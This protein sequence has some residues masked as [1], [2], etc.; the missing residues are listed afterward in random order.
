[1]ELNSTPTSQETVHDSPSGWVKRHIDEYV[2]TDGAKGK[3]WK[4]T[5]TL[6]LTTRG[7]NS[8][9]LRRTALI[10]GEYGEDF[11]VVASKGGAPEHPDWYLNLSANP[12]VSIQVGP[13]IYQGIARTATGDERRGLWNQMSGIWPDYR[14]YQ[15]RT[16]REIPVVVIEVGE[17][18]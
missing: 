14:E 4:G 17:P 12:S 2:A 11:V 8:G 3:R 18:Q 15:K 6:L 7:R 1:V 16:D 10:Y 9:K 13:D 5:D